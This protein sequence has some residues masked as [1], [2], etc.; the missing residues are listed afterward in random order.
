M[1]ASFRPF[2]RIVQRWQT[3]PMKNSGVAWLGLCVVLGLSVQCNH[4]SARFEGRIVDD[5]SGEPWPARVAV[6]DSN[7][8]PVEIEGEHAGVDYLDKH[9]LGRNPPFVNDQDRREAVRAADQALR[10][11]E[12]L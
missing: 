1:S 6:T 2:T 5:V 3:V 8:Q 11:Y 7:G 4:T 9:W 12:H 10:F